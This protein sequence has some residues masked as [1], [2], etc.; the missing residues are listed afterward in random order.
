MIP[1]IGSATEAILATALDPRVTDLGE[2]SMNNRDFTLLAAEEADAQRLGIRFAGGPELT[3]VVTDP[4]RPLGEVRVQT[5]G[6]NNVMFFDN[7]NWGGNCFAN[8]RMLGTESVT[9]FN[10]I[11]DGYVAIPDLAAML[12]NRFQI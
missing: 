11:G 6:K 4:N 2:D 7:A 8:I 1:G 3:I 10:D 12:S 5:G 9:F